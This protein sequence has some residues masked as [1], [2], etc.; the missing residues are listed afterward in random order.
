[1]AEIPEMVLLRKK[2]GL[3][4]GPNTQHPNGR[5]PA[6]PERFTGVAKKPCLRAPAGYVDGA[7]LLLVGLR[8]PPAELTS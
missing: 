2:G 5:A 4:A 8:P 1:L 7:R 6:E 3:T